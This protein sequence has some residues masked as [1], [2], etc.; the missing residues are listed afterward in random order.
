M[1]NAVI[2]VVF[3]VGKPAKINWMKEWHTGVELAKPPPLLKSVREK[4]FR[5]N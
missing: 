2:R 3:V 4:D 1:D 5:E